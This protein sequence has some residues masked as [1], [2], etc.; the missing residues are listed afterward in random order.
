MGNNSEAIF[1]ESFI[2]DP[3]FLPDEEPLAKIRAGI[4]AKTAAKQ[5][6][7]KCS[8]KKIALINHQHWFSNRLTSVRPVLA[9]RRNIG[10]NRA[11]REAAVNLGA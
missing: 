3:S 2:D 11:I 4:K 1:N 7:R 10:K 6:T 9:V 5:V 8:V